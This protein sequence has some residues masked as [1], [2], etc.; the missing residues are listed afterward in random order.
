MPR[1]P[2]TRGAVR[3]LTRVGSR[4]ETDV[5]GANLACASLVGADLAQAS[6]VYANTVSP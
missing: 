6:L 4:G 1:T 2:D 5:V 3:L